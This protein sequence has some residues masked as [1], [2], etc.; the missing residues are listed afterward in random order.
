MADYR[1][2]GVGFGL[3]AN[4]ETVLRG[5]GLTNIENPQPVTPDTVFPIA[6]IS[7]TV[8]TTAVMRL[9][10]EGRLD[11]EAPVRNYIPDFRV[12]DESASREVRLWHLL[13]HTP[14]W[15]GQLRT[16][17]RGDETLA[18]FTAGLADLPQLAPPGTVWSYNNAGFGVAGRILEI[19]TGGTIHDALSD[20]VFEPLGLTH[21]FTRTGTAMTHRFAAGHRERSGK[22]ELNRPFRLPANVAAGGAAMSVSSLL[23]YA[24]FHLGDG[25]ANGRRVLA[26]QS[27]AQMRAPRLRKNATSDE[28]GLGWHLRTLNG[29]S[30]AAHGG[31]LGGHC[32]HVQLVPERSLAFAMLTNHNEGWRLIQDV[33]QA[34]LESYASLSRAPNQATGGNR[35]GNE[36][37]RVHA[38]PLAEQPDVAPYVGT[39]QRPPN[40][41]A[42]VRA[43]GAGVVVRGGGAGENDLPLIFWGPDLAYAEPRAEGRYP[44]AGMP[45]EFIRTTDGRVGWIRI[46]GRIARKDRRAQ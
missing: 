17:D 35:G 40:G 12:Q 46:N 9:V 27:L 20:L 42:E 22:T 43:E 33:E 28:I 18:H 21:A 39:Y 10:E 44:Y 24:R 31:T 34:L 1:I 45:V 19:I 8:V 6:S 16:P 13:T 14:G 3:F 37:M 38:K 11:L 4:G 36:D 23:R 30:T 7:K 25:T 32:L 26:R 15:E 5:F 29:I 2:P 41:T